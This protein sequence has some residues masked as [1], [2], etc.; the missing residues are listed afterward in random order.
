MRVQTDSNDLSNT[1]LYPDLFKSESKSNRLN[2]VISIILVICI[3][4][5]SGFVVGRST[6]GDR[7][8]N[9]LSNRGFNTSDT[10]GFDIYTEEQLNSL[11]DLRYYDFN[12]YKHIVANI[13]DKYVEPEIIDERKLFENSLKGLVAGIGDPNTVYM[14]AEDYLKYKESLEGRFEGIGVRLAYYENRIVVNDVL[15]D[16]PAS[17]AGVK[18]GYVFLEVNGVNV[19]SYT[20]EDLVAKVRGPAGSVVKIKFFDPIS[21]TT[22]DKEIVRAAIKVDSL[23]LQERDK[24]TVVLQIYRF[25]ES[26]LK[27]WMTK[28]DSIVQEINNKGYKNIIIDLRGNGGGYLDAA[29]YAASD[30]LEPGKLVLTARTRDKSN[31]P[32]TTKQN[33]PRLKDKNVVILINGG[34]ASAS[35]ILAGALRFHKGYKL[36]GLKTYGKGTVQTIYEI[37][38]NLGA[39][40]ITVEYW[41][42]PDGQKLDKD[43]PIQPD[44]V[45]DLDQQS[46]RNGVDNQ[47][48]EAMKE[49]RQ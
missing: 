33:I 36:L 31:I 1:I 49:L 8:V 37:P 27:T 11:I 21:R 46:Y 4:V 18:N 7:I 12:L 29:V 41:L 13:K 5:T 39:L 19:E 9:F 6:F 38:N 42:L 47:I 45:V 30:F 25:T 16:S 35:E 34:T 15:P 22:I 10:T 26:D 17:K 48:E 28:W 32:I 40:K 23:R 44:K 43:N 24:D 3:S 2:T 20:L 14:T